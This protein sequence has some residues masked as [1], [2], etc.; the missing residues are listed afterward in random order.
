MPDI[1]FLLSQSVVLK[2]RQLVNGFVAVGLTGS[3]SG[4]AFP[5]RVLERDLGQTLA[6]LFCFL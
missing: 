5:E 6:Q 4:G 2:T 3:S 1:H